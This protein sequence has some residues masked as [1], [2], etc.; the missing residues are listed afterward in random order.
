MSL[1]VISATA[2]KY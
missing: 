2:W 1:N